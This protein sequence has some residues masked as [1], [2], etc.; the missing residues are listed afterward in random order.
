VIY[1]SIA[2]AL[3]L[4]SLS[5]NRG[6]L[7]SGITYSLEPTDVY[8]KNITMI[9]YT[10][11]SQ[12]REL[13]WYA[14]NITYKGNSIFF[15]NV[16]TNPEGGSIITNIDPANKTENIDVMTLFKRKG[17]DEVYWHRTYIIWWER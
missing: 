14:L 3:I 13:E 12:S 4:T 1:F 7:W 11:L 9:N 8:L 10:I 6:P 2:P 15:K 17:Q 5:S 16:T